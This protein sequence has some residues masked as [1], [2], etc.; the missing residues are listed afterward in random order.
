[1]FD[2]EQNS[3]QI[4]R[5]F[6]KAVQK[7]I[8]SP[9]LHVR[10]EGLMYFVQKFSSKPQNN[11]EV[12]PYAL[13]AADL[14]EKLNQPLKQFG[15]LWS[16]ADAYKAMGFTKECLAVCEEAHLLAIDNFAVEHQAIMLNNI[17]LAHLEH[18]EV[19]LAHEAASGAAQIWVSEQRPLEAG[20]AY[21][22]LADINRQKGDLDAACISHD[23]A[24]NHLK[25]AG[26]NRRLVEAFWRKTDL[27]INSGRWEEAIQSHSLCLA[28]QHL[29]RHELHDIPII[30]NEARLKSHQQL[31]VLAIEMFNEVLTFWRSKSNLQNLVLVTIELSKSLSAMGRK[32]QA[33]EELKAVLLVADNDQYQ[34]NLSEIQGQLELIGAKE[35]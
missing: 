14:Y 9:D 25:V 18:G 5:D 16:A 20:K 12:V 19:Q 17:A 27:L 23:E 15:A 1:V 8:E 3:H 33:E 6:E 30:Y 28:H 11:E 35:E 26:A 21:S 13:A 31:Y 2:D 10:V 4:Q 22:L 32:E 7:A 29:L 34:I 24:I